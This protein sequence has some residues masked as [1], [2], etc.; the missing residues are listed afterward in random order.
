[1]RFG[2]PFLVAGL[3]FVALLAGPAAAQMQYY[4]YYDA[5]PSAAWQAMDALFLRPAGVAT[6]LIGM[7]GFVGTL[8]VTIPS[9]TVKESA[10]AFVG[11]PAEWTFQ[12]RLGRPGWEPGFFLP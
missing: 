7:G 1:M 2:I 6:T 12:R 3:L 8:P 4:R 10:N 11:Q 5:Q 9:N